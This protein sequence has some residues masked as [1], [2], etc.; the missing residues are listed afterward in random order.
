MSNVS[1]EVIGAGVIMLPYSWQ[2]KK[3]VMFGPRSVSIRTLKANLVHLLVKDGT[4]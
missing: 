3:R 4:M 2:L 1:G